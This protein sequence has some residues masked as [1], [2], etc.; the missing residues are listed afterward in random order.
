[1]AGGDA[2]AGISKKRVTRAGKALR[3]D[4]AGR[5]TL[6]TDVREEYLATVDEFRRAHGRPL[7][8]VAANLV[9]YV[10]EYRNET[11]HKTHSH[12]FVE[13]TAD[14]FERLLAEEPSGV[15]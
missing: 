5:L 13:R 9:Y 14:L 12:Y 7:A 15:S 6:P 11:I 4:L 8:A 10:K 3:D 1:M 2:L